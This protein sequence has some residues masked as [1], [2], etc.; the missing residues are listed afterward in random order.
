M[1]YVCL[2][3]ATLFHISSLIC[4][5]VPLILIGRK[6]ILVYFVLFFISLVVLLFAPQIYYSITSVVSINKI[7]ASDYQVFPTFYCVI[8]CVLLGSQAYYFICSNEK[9]LIIKRII[10]KIQNINLNSP[11]FEER[12]LA[13]FS[14]LSW[15]L[16]I[17]VATASANN[18]WPRFH[19]FFDIFFALFISLMPINFSKKERNLYIGI[20]VFVGLFIYCYR[21]LP[22]V[23]AF[24]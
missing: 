15:I 5:F 12:N 20:F 13:F 14:I 22:Y 17:F 18:E 16:L 23:R 21:F 1:F 6:N 3:S 7:P 24:S 19:F 2:L 4:V 9:N 8:L 10:S 11:L